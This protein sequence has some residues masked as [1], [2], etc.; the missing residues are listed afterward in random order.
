VR[1]LSLHILDLAENSLRAEAS[2]VCVTVE[3]DPGTNRLRLVIEDN[4]PGLSVPPDQAADPFYT[5][6]QGKRTGLGLSFFRASAELA[7]GTM[8]LRPSDLGGLAVEATMQLNHIDRLPLG[9]LG[10]TF[11]SLACANPQVDLWCR[12]ISPGQTRLLKL[13]D[14]IIPAG[15]KSNP[16]LQAQHFARQVRAALNGL[17]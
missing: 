3:Q 11:F 6:K 15:K 12:I 17:S 10:S 5:T 1:D 9:D 14:Q 2:I 16:I 7:G 13:S 8:Q 4:G